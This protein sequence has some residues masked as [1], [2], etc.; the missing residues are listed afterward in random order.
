MSQDRVTFKSSHSDLHTQVRDATTEK[1]SEVAHQSLPTDT[2]GVEKEASSNSQTQ[3]TFNPTTGMLSPP[4]SVLEEVERIWNDF[5]REY[6]ALN[7]REE[8]EFHEEDFTTLQGPAL[9]PA[10]GHGLAGPGL[11]TDDGAEGGSSTPV[12]AVEAAAR[13]A[14]SAEKVSKWEEGTRAHTDCHSQVTKDQ[15]AREA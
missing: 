11:H 5:E 10:T 12:D 8:F 1:S 2:G 14:S 3:T 9:A 4:S 6:E 13:R 15:R 7:S